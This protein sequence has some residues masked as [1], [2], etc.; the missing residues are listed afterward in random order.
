[1]VAQLGTGIMGAGMARSM[2]RAGLP[3]RV[4]N[5][6]RA[7]AKAL[8]AD[9]AVIASTPADAAREADVLVTMLPD[10]ATVEDVMRQAEPGLRAGQAWAQTSTVGVPGVKQ[11]G[12]LATGHGL[13]FVDAPV[14]GTR[15]PAE[16]GALTV[17]AAGPDRAREW[18][19]PVF[20][21]IGDKTVWLGPA[22]GAASRLKLVVNNW[23]LAVTDATGETL[24]L[25]RALGVDPD[26]FVQAVSG[27]PL[28]CL[29]MQTKAAAI[30]K[31]D[32]TPN[33]SVAMAGKDADLIVAASEGASVRLEGAEAVARRFRRAVEMGH[34]DEDMAAVY[35]ASF[36]ADQSDDGADDQA[37]RG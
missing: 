14:L 18:V 16:R 4:W 30:M 37:D 21:A 33:F 26:L 28:D 11:L 35:F 5:R 9:G 31:G 10:A 34:S 6:T 17:F 20:D 8:E 12:R 2:L 23:V 19:Q 32:F 7:R 24:A 29:Y 15:Q 13:V 25:A 1:M 3:V 22:A 27:G 36:P